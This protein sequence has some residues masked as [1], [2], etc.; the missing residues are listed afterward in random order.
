MPPGVDTRDTV[1]AVLLSA[2]LGKILLRRFIQMQ[3]LVLAL[4][5]RWIDIP[6]LMVRTAL[7]IRDGLLRKNKDAIPAGIISLRS[8]AARNVLLHG[9]KCLVCM[10]KRIGLASRKA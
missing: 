7:R 3:A 9:W 2:M 10:N 5:I 8:M 4:T 1:V 6:I